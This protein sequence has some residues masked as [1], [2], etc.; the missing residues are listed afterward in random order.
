MK[1]VTTVEGSVEIFTDKVL[2]FT[3]LMDEAA[4]RHDVRYELGDERIVGSR[5]LFCRRFV[6]LMSIKVIGEGRD[7]DNFTLFTS[8]LAKD[9]CKI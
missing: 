2:L 6:S 3:Q 1:T 5:G 9:I 8:V 7:V 4:K